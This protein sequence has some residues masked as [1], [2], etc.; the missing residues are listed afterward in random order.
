MEI[1]LIADLH[2]PLINS[3]GFEKSRNWVKFTKC[4]VEL[5]KKGVKDI[6]LLGDINGELSVVRGQE[7][8]EPL[9]KEIEMSYPN[10][11]WEYVAG[12]HDDVLSYEFKRKIDWDK[13]KNWRVRSYDSSQWNNCKT[14]KILLLSHL[15]L[16]P[17]HKET[18]DHWFMEN[19]PENLW[20]KNDRVYQS[21]LQIE[22]LNSIIISGHF[23]TPH[24]YSRKIGKCTQYYVPASSFMVV[25]DGLIYVDDK[26]YGYGIFDSETGKV[27]FFNN[28]LK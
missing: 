10:M 9:L 21:Q 14:D 26:E 28:K 3:V 27:E 5:K 25:P 16:F 24:G 12:N 15:P 22:F 23:H 11:N 13:I 19:N 17:L 2:L 1:G 18:W 7:Y 20:I 4:V 8:T 6:V